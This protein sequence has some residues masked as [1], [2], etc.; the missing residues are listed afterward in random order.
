MKNWY[1]IVIICLIASIVGAVLWGNRA[2]DDKYRAE[3]KEWKKRTEQVLQQNQKI[4]HVVDSI[5]TVSDSAKVIATNKTIE[6]NK[7]RTSVGTL[8]IKNDKT[9]GELHLT[10][11]DTCK[12]ALQLAESYSKE[13]DTLQVALTL[14]DVRDS[15]RVSDIDR[16]R[17]GLTLQKQ[18]NDSL[19]NLIRTVPIYK[20]PKLF[21]IVSLPS[22]KISFLVGAVVG[23]IAVIQVVR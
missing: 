21:G 20:S 16:L 11:P 19:V 7:L 6:I 9:L 13:A 23:G 1:P 5:T 10:L 4:Q 17:F 15:I 22:R 14:A 12:S 18:V 2:D 3:I 8:R